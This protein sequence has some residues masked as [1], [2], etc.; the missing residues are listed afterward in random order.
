[1]ASSWPISAL[2]LTA[3]ASRLATDHSEMH[4]CDIEITEVYYDL[5]SRLHEW[6]DSYGIEVGSVPELKR[7]RGAESLFR[8]PGSSP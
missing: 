6:T 1:M 5:V 3:I 2:Y 4:L 8:Y 7:I